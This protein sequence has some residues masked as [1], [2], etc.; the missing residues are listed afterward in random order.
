MPFAP[1]DLFDTAG[2]RTTY[3]SALFRDHVPTRTASAVQRIVDAG[4]VIVG[5]ANLHEFAWGVTS[6][7][8]FYG[9]VG[10][11]RRPGHIAGRLVGRQRRGPR[12]RASPP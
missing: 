1:K 3:G 11:P 6:K 4:A 8:P 10:N 9:T 12:P 7:N 5:K 2:M